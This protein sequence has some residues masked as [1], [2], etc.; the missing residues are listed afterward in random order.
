MD[1]SM[2][3]LNDEEKKNII[4]CTGMDNNIHRCVSWKNTTYVDKKYLK[5][6]FNF[7]IKDLLVM[8]VNLSKKTF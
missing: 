4:L 6:I 7:H 1:H 8:N 5:K 3:K 2:K